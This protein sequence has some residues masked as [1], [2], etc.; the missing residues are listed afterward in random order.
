MLAFALMISQAMES[1][2]RAFYTRSDLELI[3]SSPASA[4]RIFSLRIVIMAA[5]SMLMALLL[6]GPFINVMAFRFGPHWLAAYGVVFSM[7][8]AA[9]ALAVAFT[10]GLFRTI[11]A[12][13]TRLIAQIVAAVIGAA[14]VIGLQIGA[15][16]SYG[17]LSRLAFLQSDTLA[18]HLPDVTSAVWLPARA[19]LGVPHPR[20]LPADV[21]GVA[22]V[23]LRGGPEDCEVGVE[24]H[25]RVAPG[26]RLP[27]RAVLRG[28]DHLHD[29]LD[30]RRGHPDGAEQ[31]DRQLPA[32]PLVVLRARVVHRVV[33]PDRQ[34]QGGR[35]FHLRG[36]PVGTW[37]APAPSAED[38]D[39]AAS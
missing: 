18:A 34:V 17:N 39:V 31:I 36:E 5:G 30:G 19:I 8:A 21:G 24:Q 16:L 22:G 7:G 32:A 4:R 27:L 13:R 26:R 25:A 33:E 3:L 35:L 20:V 14:F 9:A 23:A 1:V 6:A 15:I 28:P 37:F 12:K 2:T 10:I 38:A 11:G 29:A